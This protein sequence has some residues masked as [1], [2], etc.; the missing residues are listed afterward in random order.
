MNRCHIHI[1]I[2]VPKNE[3][4]A[5]INR[6]CLYINIMQLNAHRQ[7]QEMVVNLIGHIT[8]RLN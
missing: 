7:Q 6:I 3:N 4:Q 5:I 2:F 1:T 8:I